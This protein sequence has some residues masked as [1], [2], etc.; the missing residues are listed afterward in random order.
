VILGGAGGPPAYQRIARLTPDGAFDPEFGSNGLVPTRRLAS[1]ALDG[2][3]RVLTLGFKGRLTRLSSNGAPDGSFSEGGTAAM[4]KANIFLEYERGA[5]ATTPR[6]GAVITMTR[7]KSDGTGTSRVFLTQVGPN[8][9]VVRSFGRDGL[10]RTGF[11]AATDG[12]VFVEGSR[13]ALVPVVMPAPHGR[14]SLGWLRY[15][16][17]R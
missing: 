12:A 2:S 1:I 7:G 8:G 5:I 15:D 3:G 16:L 9:K 6:G 17:G 10:A 4:P 14:I 13:R 11:E